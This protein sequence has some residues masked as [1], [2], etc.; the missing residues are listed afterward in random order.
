MIEKKNPS[1]RERLSAIETT[2][3]FVKEEIRDIKENHLKSLS[4]RQWW[5]LGTVLISILLGIAGLILRLIL[6]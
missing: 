2:I 5:L 3:I 1:V 6:K 4:D